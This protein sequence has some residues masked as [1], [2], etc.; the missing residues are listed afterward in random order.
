MQKR[1]VLLALLVCLVSGQIWAKVSMPVPRHYVEDQANVINGSTE[2]SL[3]GLLQELE[4]KTGAQYIVLTVETMQGLPIEQFSIELAEK[5]RLG[6]KGKDNGML[7]VLAVKERMYR[8]EVGYGLEGF[9][10]DQ[11]CGRIGRN[12]LVPFLKQ[13]DYSNGILQ[14]TL[15]VAKRIASEYGVQ[16]SGIPNIPTTQPR[17]RGRR[18][19]LPFCGGLP[20]ILL[21]LLLFGGGRGGRGGGWLFFLPFMMGGFGGHRGY[22]GYGRSGSYGGGSFGGGFGGFGGGSGGG[23]GGGGASGGW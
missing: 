20:F 22:G 6:Q 18:R 1:I 17:N 4:Q 5:W 2:R 21:M 7:F 11:D 16:L 10:T 13:N 9:I 23:F 12:V 19:G 8:F 14:A 3:N 15:E